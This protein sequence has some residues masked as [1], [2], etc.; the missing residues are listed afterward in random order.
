MASTVTKC[1]FFVAKI[2]VC[3]HLLVWVVCNSLDFYLTNLTS[4]WGSDRSEK[5]HSVSGLT[6]K[7]DSL[8]T[9]IFFLPEMC[10]IYGWVSIVVSNWASCFD[11]LCKSGLFGEAK[12]LVVIQTTGSLSHQTDIALFLSF[13]GLNWAGGILRWVL[14]VA[15]MSLFWLVI[16]DHLHWE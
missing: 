14:S 10:S 12:P 15:R 1:I 9:L 11:I 5:I 4:L 6:K 2:L 13:Y 8:S 3:E 16:P 7:R